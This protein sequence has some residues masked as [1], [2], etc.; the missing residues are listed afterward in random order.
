MNRHNGVLRP[1]EGGQGGRPREGGGGREW[2]GV[3]DMPKSGD[4]D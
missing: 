2:L 1:R 4:I 3:Y